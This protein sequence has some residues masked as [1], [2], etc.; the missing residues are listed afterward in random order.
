MAVVAYI[1]SCPDRPEQMCRARL[2]FR[3][4]AT[5][6]SAAEVLVHNISATDIVIEGDL[7]LVWNDDLEVS[8]PYAGT[9]AAT[10]VWASERLRGCKFRAPIP[11]ATLGAA[12]LRDAVAPHPEAQPDAVAGVDSFGHRLHELRVAKG[13]TQSQLARQLRVSEPSISHWEK[14]RSRPKA[15][16][17]EALAAI[18]GV[19]MPELLGYDDPETLRKLVDA[20]KE[21]IAR[22]AGASVEKIRI[23]IDM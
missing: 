21:Q 22:A 5:R 3:P 9:V 16:R 13:L 18:F 6:G 12:K 10:V 23:M 15:G 14:D 7:L 20:A 17:I 2:R 11:A 1:E 19:P 4:A 8:L